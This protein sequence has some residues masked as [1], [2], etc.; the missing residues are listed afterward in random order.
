MWGLAEAAV[1]ALKSVLGTTIVRAPMRGGV[2][3]YPFLTRAQVQNLWDGI[4]VFCLP[5]STEN[6]NRRQED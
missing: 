5:A 3:M 4:Q 1:R 6:G 2:P